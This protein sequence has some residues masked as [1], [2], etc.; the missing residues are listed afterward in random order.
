SHSKGLRRLRD[1]MRSAAST[2]G[3]SNTANACSEAPDREASLPRDLSVFRDVS[4]ALR[5]QAPHLV[6]TWG[7]DLRPVQRPGNDRIRKPPQRTT[8]CRLRHEPGG[9]LY[10][11]C[12]DLTSY[13]AGD[14]S[15]PGAA[16]ARL[17]S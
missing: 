1:S 16:P 17:H 15:A 4:G 5:P 9:R 12:K 6:Q 7:L 14:T 11:P 10:L 2:T 3:S 13:E 8:G